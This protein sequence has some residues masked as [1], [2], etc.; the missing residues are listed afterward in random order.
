MAGQLAQIMQDADSNHQTLGRMLGFVRRLL[1]ANT[2]LQVLRAAEAGWQEDFALP[3]GR[4]W[5]LAEPPKKVRFPATTG[6]LKPCRPCCLVCPGRA[7]V[8][9]PHRACAG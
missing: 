6:Y 2:L 1:A 8:R 7:A 3:A 5:L 9:Q 4:V